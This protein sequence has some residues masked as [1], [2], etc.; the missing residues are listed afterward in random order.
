LFL[1]KI[2]FERPD[3]EYDLLEIRMFNVGGINGYIYIY[4]YVVKI[5]FPISSCLLA[6]STHSFNG[7]L[8]IT[9]LDKQE[10]KRRAGLSKVP[11]TLSEDASIFVTRNT[12]DI[13]QCP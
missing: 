4:I 13:P 1:L 7:V 6:M 11:N 10:K 8:L 3:C 12:L 5:Y 2:S 9:A